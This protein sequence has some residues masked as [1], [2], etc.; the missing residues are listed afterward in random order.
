MTTA[1]ARAAHSK[2][3]Y[4]VGL[5]VLVASAL[6]LLW[7]EHEAHILGVLPYAILLLCPLM[8]IFMHGG[9]DYGDRDHTRATQP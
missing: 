8:H 5:C 1:F 4:L 9:H 7:E 2:V 3:P 6:F